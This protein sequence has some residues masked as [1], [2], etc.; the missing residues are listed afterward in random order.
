MRIWVV[1][2]VILGC[3]KDETHALTCP[4]SPTCPPQVTC[5][6]QPTTPANDTLCPGYGHLYQQFQLGKSNGY[7]GI[8]IVRVAGSNMAK[9]YVKRYIKFL[10]NGVVHEML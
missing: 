9:D 4:P 8:K 3:L 10:F 6:P 2:C 1:L 7:F 5:P